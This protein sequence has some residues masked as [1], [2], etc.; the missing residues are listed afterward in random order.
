M[1][2]PGR[3][4][5]GGSDTRGGNERGRRVPGGSRWCHAAG[6]WPSPEPVSSCPGSSLLW[7]SGGGSP[8]A[9]P[10]WRNWA[11]GRGQWLAFL[12][13]LEHVPCFSGDAEK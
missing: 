6:S 12:L 7:L 5:R 9:C 13:G 1:G 11:F 10:W 2:F 8:L 4:Q 3:A